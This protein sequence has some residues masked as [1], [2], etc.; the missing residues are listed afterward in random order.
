MQL[1]YNNDSKIVLGD[2]IIKE[3]VDASLDESDDNLRELYESAMKESFDI[4]KIVESC[5]ETAILQSKY[6]DE[7]IMVD[8]LTRLADRLQSIITKID[9]RDSISKE[10][11]IRM[12]LVD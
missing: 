2:D 9:S 5:A 6:V 1:E 11:A 3:M 8:Y 10:E 12:V 4:L 7:D